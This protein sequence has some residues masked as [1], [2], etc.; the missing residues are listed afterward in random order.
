MTCGSYHQAVELW[1]N[2]TQELLI[3]LV[4]FGKSQ[5]VMSLSLIPKIG[6]EF[7]KEIYIS[8]D[9]NRKTVQ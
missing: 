6:N 8:H 1:K 3:K 4:I 7:L 2:T 9:G 5:L